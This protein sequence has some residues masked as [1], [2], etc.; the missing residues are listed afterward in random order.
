MLK[1]SHYMVFRT[2]M[3][4]KTASMLWSRKYT[5]KYWP[6]KA[7]DCD[8]FFLLGPT[9]L[10]SSVSTTAPWSS[11]RTRP[12]KSWFWYRMATVHHHCLLVQGPASTLDE[13]SKPKILSIGSDYKQTFSLLHVQSFRTCC[14]VRHILSWRETAV[15]GQYRVTFSWTSMKGN[16]TLLLL[17]GTITICLSRLLLVC[18]ISNSRNKIHL[19]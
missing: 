17:D 10:L 11:S 7:W 15:F 14:W 8:G 9:M 18:F 6:T 12:E 1:S 13:I 3:V 16:R 5:V 4:H 19:S 2:W